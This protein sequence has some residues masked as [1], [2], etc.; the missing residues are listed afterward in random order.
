MVVFLSLFTTL[1]KVDYTQKEYYK[2]T[3]NQID[4]IARQSKSYHVS[5]WK[6]GWGETP[7]VPKEAIDFAGY[8]RKGKFEFVADSTKVRTILINGGDFQL[9]W[10]ELDLL[11]ITPTLKKAIVKAIQSKFPHIQNF[12]F[13]ASHTHKSFGGWSEDVA[14]KFLLGGFQKEVMD[15]LVNQSL[16]ATQKAV[17]S[18]DSVNI[19]YKAVESG[20]WVKN[21]LNEKFYEDPYLRI[22]TFS[23]K[24]GQKALLAT[25]SAHA[26]C[27]SSK[28]KG[29]SGDYPSLVSQL[30]TRKD[31]ELAILCAG[32]VGSHSATAKDGSYEALNAYSQ[33]LLKEFYEKPIYSISL[34]NTQIRF[35]EFPFYLPEPQWRIH[36]DFRFRTW[37]F[38][39]LMSEAPKD[40]NFTYLQIG[41]LQ[42]LG[43]PCDFSG[44]LYPDIQAN[45]KKLMITSF[46]GSYAGYFSH[47]NHYF[48]D[49][50]E[51]RDMNWYGETATP[52]LLEVVNHILTRMR[53]EKNN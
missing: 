36:P 15:M 45:P 20:E 25:F 14:G 8:G 7:I 5:S 17:S 3:L 16:L 21:R 31:Y 9:L 37:V 30:L 32:A 28:Y 44:E 39:W 49:K 13:T 38:E 42:F 40:A 23:K 1:E 19:S 41:E 43:A 11:I 34:E 50:A 18:L 47:Q 33:N 2:N 24:N 12:Y 35:A 27:L 46:N 10:I 51:T 53:I 29:L 22:L 48:M 6:A 4:I 52:Y 26:T